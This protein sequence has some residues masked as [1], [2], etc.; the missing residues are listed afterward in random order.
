MVRAGRADQRDRRMRTW[1]LVADGARSVAGREFETSAAVLWHRLA[2]VRALR[3]RHR[4]RGC[5][6]RPGAEHLAVYVWP[7]RVR[8]GNSVCADLWRGPR[9]SD[10]VAA[11]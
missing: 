10:L 3:D 5:V 11:D 6:A 8:A 7:D 4:V 1:A 9:H 2:C